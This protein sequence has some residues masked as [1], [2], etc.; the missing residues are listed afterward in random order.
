MVFLIVPILKGLDIQIWVDLQVVII[1]KI[2]ITDL[3][4]VCNFF[5]Y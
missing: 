5:F 1:T 4:L 2:N 3:K